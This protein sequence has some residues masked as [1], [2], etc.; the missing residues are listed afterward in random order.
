MK[1]SRISVGIACGVLATLALA[2]GGEAPPFKMTAEEEKLLE[3]T[4]QER[5]KKELPPLRGNPLLSKIARSHSENMAK[6]GKMDHT[7]DSKTPFDRMRDAEY[8]FLKGAENIA[9]GDAKNALAEIVRAWME[10]KAHRENILG[11]DYTETGL[12]MA[13]DKSGQ[14][15]YTQVFAKP[16]GKG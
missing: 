4:N 7:L 1:R 15:Y 6:Q 9:A 14:I 3:L 16:Q 2:R 12:G 8:K 11:P 13:R 10:S 5:K